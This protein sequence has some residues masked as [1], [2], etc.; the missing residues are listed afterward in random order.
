VVQLADMVNVEHLK[1]K[2]SFVN[3]CKSCHERFHNGDLPIIEKVRE[4]YL[5]EFKPMINKK[6]KGA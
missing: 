4:L 1:N 5:R 6:Q 2:V 3:L